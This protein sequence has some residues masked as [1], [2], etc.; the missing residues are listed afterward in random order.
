MK[1]RCI[2]CKLVFK[3]ALTGVVD[4]IVAEFRERH[5]FTSNVSRV[6]S[7]FTSKVRKYVALDPQ[8][9]GG[10]EQ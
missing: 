1:F 5:I 3:F 6:K 9:K 7:V 10:N 8:C 2:V 4:E